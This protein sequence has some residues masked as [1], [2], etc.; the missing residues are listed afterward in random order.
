METWRV[1]TDW[2]KLMEIDV[3]GTI[4]LDD[5]QRRVDAMANPFNGGRGCQ[6]TWSVEEAINGWKLKIHAQAQAL[7]GHGGVMRMVPFA[8]VRR[9]PR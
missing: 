1:L 2:Q 5:I 7:P 9:S 8:S 4:S 3:P 6:F